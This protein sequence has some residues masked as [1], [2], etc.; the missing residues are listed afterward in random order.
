MHTP[1]RPLRFALVVMGV[2]GSGKTSIGAAVAKR[3]GIG[4]V[5]GDDLHPAAN[6][7]KMKSGEPLTDGDR[8]PW[9]DRVGAVLRDRAAYPAGVAVACS[10]L[11]RS[12]RDRI[13]GEAAGADTGF[14]FLDITP[15][16]SEARLKGRKG[17]F[18]PVSLV[19]S[20]FETLER[21]APDETD[22]ITVE[23]TQGFDE[24]VSKAANAL[25]GTGG[26]E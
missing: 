8:W 3:L 6:V 25:V 1:A 21:P 23:E 13:R 24:T 10:A 20:Q 12:Y 14:L 18:M 22:I 9:L 2:S 4:F 5:D 11:R 19:Q 16:V 17:H 7:A 26:A 15:A